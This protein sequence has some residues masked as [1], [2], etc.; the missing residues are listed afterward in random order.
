M[1]AENRFLKFDIQMICV[2]IS[3]LDFLTFDTVN[4]HY[5]H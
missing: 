1:A 2:F 4:V 3:L 5:H